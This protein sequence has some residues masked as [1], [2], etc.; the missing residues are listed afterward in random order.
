M[1]FDGGTTEGQKAELYVQMMIEGAKKLEGVKTFFTCWKFAA[2]EKRYSCQSRQDSQSGWEE[3]DAFIKYPSLSTF[4]WISWD[5][6][7]CQ[8]CHAFRTEKERREYIS[9]C[10]HN[11]F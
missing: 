9:G 4:P 7:Y 10:G 3:L 2:G 5:F 6:V 11:S 8:Q 1:G